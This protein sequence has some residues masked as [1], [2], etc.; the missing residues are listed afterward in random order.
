M[1]NKDVE[2]SIGNRKKLTKVAS[3]DKWILAIP[4]LVRKLIVPVRKIIGHLSNTERVLIGLDIK[5]DR[6]L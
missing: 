5:Y 3:A 6:N 2:N 1:K 4:T